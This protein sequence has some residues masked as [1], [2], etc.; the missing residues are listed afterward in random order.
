[1]RPPTRFNRALI[2]GYQKR[3]LREH[4]TATEPHQDIRNQT[5]NGGGT[6]YTLLSSRC[7][8]V[9]FPC[10]CY[11]FAF[12]TPIPNPCPHS[13]TGLPVS[14]SAPNPQSSL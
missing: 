13:P 8:L 6:H 10:K 1:M 7:H 2:M 9:S 5:Q 11:K 3:K 12:F 4:C 14:N